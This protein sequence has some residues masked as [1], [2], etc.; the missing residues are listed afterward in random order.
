MRM[1]S[2]ARPRDTAALALT[3]ALA[4]VA[5][6][7]CSSSEEPRPATELVGFVASAAEQANG[8]IPRGDVVK[9]CG[10]D[11]YGWLTEIQHTS[12]ASAR[13]RNR[14]GAF[15][16]SASGHGARQMMASG[17][18]TTAGLG[19]T[20]VPFDH[21]FGG[22]LSLDVKLDRSYLGLGQNLGAAG[23][24][25]GNPRDTVHAELM[26]GLV[27]HVPG[28]VTV[29]P[30]QD[31][32]A[33]AEATT[34]GLLPDFQPRRDDRVALMGSWV[35]DCGHPDFHSELHSISFLAFAHREGAGT[36]ARA[37]YNPYEVTQLYN[38]D[39]SLSH[40][41]NDASRFADPRTQDSLGYFASEILRLAGLAQPVEDQVRLPHLLTAFNDSPAPWQVCAPSDATGTGLATSYA[42]AVRPGVSV[43]V[44][45][46]DSKGCV[47]VTT[48]VTGAY[49][50]LD[51]PGQQECPTQWSWLSSAAVREG[52]GGIG[53]GLD[54]P[55]EIVNLLSR[56]PLAGVA[57]SVKAKLQRPVVSD[58]YPP[59]SAAG[60]PAPGPGLQMVTTSASQA[61]PMVGWVRV[62]RP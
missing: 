7:S 43:Q 10:S 32:P 31:W 55:T 13:V 1:S 25:G 23:E 34:S 52:E 58:C 4:L 18:I 37:F 45:P 39:A 46:L 50:A 20:D 38:P 6:Q 62:A 14:W 41:V 60:L 16:P 9:I 56:T 36:I 24:S 53:A 30:G 59:L 44:S 29:S 19:A 54:L 12:F 47:T 42:F 3:M 5:G 8:A 17:T 61:F 15:I 26:A 35:V 2:P 28:S 11:R 22:D 51:P 33:F 40:L 49:Q 21:P 27:P 48:S 57:A